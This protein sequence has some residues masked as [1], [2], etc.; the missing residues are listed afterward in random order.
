MENKLFFGDDVSELK[1]CFYNVEKQTNSQP[2]SLAIWISSE[3]EK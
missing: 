3:S 1:G 2:E